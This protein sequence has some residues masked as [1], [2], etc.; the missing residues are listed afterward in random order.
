MNSG[1]EKSLQI[2]AQNGFDTL[3]SSLRKLFG[4]T[5]YRRWFVQMNGTVSDAAD[6]TKSISLGLPT[7]FM[8]DWVESHFGEE[9]RYAWKG[10]SN[11]GQVIFSVVSPLVKTSA[12]SPVSPKISETVSLKETAVP[13]DDIY[14]GFSTELNPHLTFDNF[15]VGATNELAYAAARRAADTDVATFN[16]LFL[17]GGVGLGKTHLMQ[18]V[19]W[20]IKQKNP[21][22]K[23]IYLSAEKFMYH[24]VMALRQKDTMKF[25]EVFNS[26]DVLI[27][28]DIQFISGKESTQ[29]EFFH[30][31]NTMLSRGKQL[32]LSA[33]KAPQELDRIEE[34]LKSRLSGG[35]VIALNP[36]DF[37]LRLG[38]L[39][40]KTKKIGIELPEKV[41]EFLAYKISSNVRELEGALN[42]IIAY[43]QLAKKT[44]TLE[45]AQEVLKDVLRSCEKKITIDEIQ[46]R[47]AEHYKIKISDMQSARRARAVARPRQVAMYLC[48]EMTDE[49]FER[50][51]LEFG[52]KGHATVIYGCNKIATELKSNKELK[53]AI[54]NIE[55]ELT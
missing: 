46:K 10:M 33:D 7:R 38:I 53:D 3:I 37:N 11:N 18:S 39:Q 26:I 34:R 15:I 45:L 25:K 6:G 21:E 42:R 32:V 35:L 44:V 55:R 43:T 41:L 52:G 9:I 31:L 12:V 22:K 47:V 29:E 36:I 17:C 4:E 28:D 30:A 8:R 14:S 13:V 24:F 1:S 49:P 16:P 19:A 5:I 23:V 48:R 51:G 54:A 50:I 40:A 20:Q 27:V 2:N